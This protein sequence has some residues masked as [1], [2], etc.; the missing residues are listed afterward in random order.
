LQEN[1]FGRGVE[2]EGL[3]LGPLPL[4]LLP[5]IVE[6]TKDA[7]IVAATFLAVAKK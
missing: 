2:L 4:P 7:L 5:I 6:A 1:K 3:E